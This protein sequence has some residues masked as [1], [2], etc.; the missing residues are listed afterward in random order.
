MLSNRRGDG[1]D[2]DRVKVLRG[3]VWAKLDELLHVHVVSEAAY[4][5]VDVSHNLWGK[6][7]S[8][9]LKKKE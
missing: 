5:N 9:V 2:L 7:G 3:L 1:L 4:E 8:I 6:K